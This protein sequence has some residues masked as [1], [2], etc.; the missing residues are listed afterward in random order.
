MFNKKI[1]LGIHL[2]IQ[3]VQHVKISSYIYTSSIN[4]SEFDYIRRV[5]KTTGSLI[6]ALSQISN[7]RFARVTVS[8]IYTGPLS[9]KCLINAA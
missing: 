1:S 5:E 3:E 6:Q 2:S 7:L 8:V 9:I 4:H